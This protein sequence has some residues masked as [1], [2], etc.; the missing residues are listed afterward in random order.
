MMIESLTP[1]IQNLLITKHSHFIDEAWSI[2][3]MRRIRWALDHFEYS[4]AYEIDNWYFK[5]KQLLKG[6]GHSLGHMKE[7]MKSAFSTLI[8]ISLWLIETKHTDTFH[9]LS[10]FIR[11][12]YYESKSLEDYVKSKLD[13]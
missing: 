1:N 3:D 7:E 8:Q 11:F 4:V 9:S 6:K 10:Y 2:G 13:V 12:L 5:M